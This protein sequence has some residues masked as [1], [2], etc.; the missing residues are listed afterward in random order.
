LP[1]LLVPVVALEAKH[2]GNTPEERTPENVWRVAKLT[3]AGVMLWV[4]SDVLIAVLQTLG[5]SLNVY[6]QC[7]A[8]QH[9]TLFSILRFT[10][11]AMIFFAF[12]GGFWMGKVA[13]S[14]MFLN[15][16]LVLWILIQT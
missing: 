6:V 13:R 8:L 3:L 14:V 1:F 5:L 12:W 11:I 7:F 4:A 16:I 2:F 9:D 15:I 10:A